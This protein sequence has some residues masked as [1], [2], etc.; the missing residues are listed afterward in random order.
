MLTGFLP[1]KRKKER[2][3]F[4]AAQEVMLRKFSVKQQQCVLGTENVD[5]D[6]GSRLQ[7]RTL[8]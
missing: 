1:E 7:R 8:H 2:K 4:H 5:C 3:V 6:C